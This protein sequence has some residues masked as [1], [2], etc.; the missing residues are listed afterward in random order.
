[1]STTNV[2]RSIRRLVALGACVAA[3]SAA[4]PL[5][6]AQAEGRH[7]VSGRFYANTMSADG[8]DWLDRPERDFE[9][10]TNRAIK[11]L[12]L[13]QGMVVADIGAG[14][15]YFTLPMAKLVRPGGRVYAVD[16]QRR[17]LDIIAKKLEKQKKDPLD[18]VTLILGE[19]DDPKLPAESIDVALMVDVYHELHQPQAVL[20]AIRTA[21]KPTGRLILLEYRAEDPTVPIQT[22]H[23]MSVATA[24][25][26]V[27]N[28]GFT[29]AQV[30]KDLPW[31]HLLIFTRR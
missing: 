22:L 20:E 25:L 27:E 10:S 2:M 11:L 6:L 28:E 9:E 3:F 7:P 4:V 26:E 23:K 8:A 1:M 15:G 21:L 5:V 19:A 13:T 18:N 12:G 29:L 24:K 17:M 14:S 30:K 31:Q 16:I